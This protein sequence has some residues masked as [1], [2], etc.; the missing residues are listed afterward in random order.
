MSDGCRACSAEIFFH[1]RM[2]RETHDPYKHFT[3]GIT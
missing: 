3:I 1:P 2:A